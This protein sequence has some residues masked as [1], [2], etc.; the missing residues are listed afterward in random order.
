MKTEFLFLWL[1]VGLYGLSAFSYVFGLISKKEKLFTIGTIFA[2]AGVLPHVSTVALRWIEAGSPPFIDI[3]ESITSGVL[4]GMIIFLIVQFSIKRVRAIGVLAMPVTFV[5][6]GWAGTLFKPVSGELSASLQS[7]WLW[8]HIFAASTGFGSVLIAAGMGL[9]FLLKDKYKSGLYE[10]LPELNALDNLSYRYVAA[11]FIML[12][13]MLIS[14][15]FWS[16]QAKGNYWN[17]DP[18]EVWSLI[19]WLFY[20]IYLHLRITMGWRGK[21]LAWYALLALIVMI[22]SYWGIPFVTETFHKGFRIEH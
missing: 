15:A 21:R 1:A 3:A 7:Y 14:G 22:T 4:V 6:L 2:C 19:C 9:L 10:K 8:V 17:W 20:G 18:V 5:L 12:G 16:N 11:G 13:L